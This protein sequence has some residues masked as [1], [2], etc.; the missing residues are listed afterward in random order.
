MHLVGVYGSLRQNLENSHLLKTSEYLGEALTQPEWTLFD[1]GPYPALVPSGTT[2]VVLE[3]YRVTPD[4]L[5]HLDHLEDCP[6]WYQRQTQATPWGNCW[7]Y[8]HPQ[9][10]AEHHTPVPGGDWKAYFLA[11]ANS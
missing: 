1:L 4:T 6:D 9:L 2:A 3:V 10:T 8:I 5:A 7:I 11:R